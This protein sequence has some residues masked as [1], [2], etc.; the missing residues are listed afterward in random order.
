MV[1]QLILMLCMLCTTLTE[2]FKSSS[3]HMVDST[4]KSAIITSFSP[5]IHTKMYHYLIMR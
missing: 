2:G 3:K 4:E 5:I 1:K